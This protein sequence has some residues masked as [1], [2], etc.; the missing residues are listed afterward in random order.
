VIEH[1]APGFDNVP[2]T[3]RSCQ[4]SVVGCQISATRSLKFETRNGPGGRRGCQHCRTAAGAADKNAF[5]IAPA[6]KAAD[7]ASY[8]L[9]FGNVA[10]E[11]IS[12]QLW[13]VSWGKVISYQLSVVRSATATR[14]R[15]QMQSAKFQM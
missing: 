13:A 5:W 15:W 3:G 8:T 10:G 12:Y 4:L 11:A 1:Y 6:C 7:I 9:D 2:I 14:R